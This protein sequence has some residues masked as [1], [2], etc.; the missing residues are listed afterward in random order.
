MCGTICDH[1]SEVRDVLSRDTED[2]STL[3]EAPTADHNDVKHDRRT[4]PISHLSTPSVGE[5]EAE[6]EYTGSPSLAGFFGDTRPELKLDDYS[7]PSVKPTRKQ[8][9][10]AKPYITRKAPDAEQ[11]YLSDSQVLSASR[12][13]TTEVA[14]S[15]LVTHKPN[16]IMKYA[17]AKGT[18]APGQPSKVIRA[19]H[20]FLQ[21]ELD[22]L[23]PTDVRFA[24]VAMG[25]VA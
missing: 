19:K 22:E 23:E 18:V 5:S 10:N 2:D 16:K 6:L 8:M 11:G 15:W 17:I 1:M 4:W 7:T 24:Q 13:T 12:E 20:K 21:M 3:H 9:A 25:Y 14:R